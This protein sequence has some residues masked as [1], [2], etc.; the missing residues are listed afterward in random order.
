MSRLVTIYNTLG[1]N[2]IPIES[3]ATTWGQLKVNLV[4][5]AV[6]YLDMKAIVG[7]TQVTL[8][9]SEA[10]LPLGDCTIMLFPQKVKSGV[11]EEGIDGDGNDNDDDDMPGGDEDDNN[12][13]SP[14]QLSELP[15]DNPSASLS[16]YENMLNDISIVE[17]KL[18]N[19]K[20]GL[21]NMKAEWSDPETYALE[22]QANDIRKN[23]C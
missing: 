15:A 20:A 4:D 19:I 9:S 23:L 6:P 22:Q 18:A 8:E 21:K 16:T 10:L 3:D 1:S 14:V 7:D 5:Y 11:E 12:D 2:R 13:E 17:G